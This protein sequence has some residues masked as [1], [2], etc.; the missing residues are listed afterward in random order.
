MLTLQEIKYK[1]GHMASF[2]LWQKIDKSQK[3]KFGMGD[4]SHFDNLENLNINRNIILVGLNISGKIENPFQN[5]HPTSP[6]AHDYK[7]RYAVQD[8]IFSGAY[9]TDIIK[10]YEEVDG[11]K[12]MEFLNANPDLKKKNIKLFEQE[13][14]DIGSNN[15][16]I[17]AMGV[18]AE[19][20]LKPLKEKYKIFK[21]PHY[22]SIYTKEYIRDA[23]NDIYLKNR[24]LF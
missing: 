11:S 10:D 24:N 13:L 2:A 14:K 21:V 15:P 12:L 7:T 19:L 9:M 16:I 5:F 3:P 1:Y 17:I 18:K 23:F 22:S 8:T 20:L 4:I 6:F